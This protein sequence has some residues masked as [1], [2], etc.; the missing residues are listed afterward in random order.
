MARVKITPHNFK[1]KFLLSSNTKMKLT[2]I[3]IYQHRVNVINNDRTALFTVEMSSYYKNWITAYECYG[4]D[5]SV[6]DFIDDI[7][8]SVGIDENLLKAII[9]METRNCHSNPFHRAHPNPFPININYQLWEPIVH[10]LGYSM[11]DIKYSEM[12]RVHLAAVVLKRIALR[13][14]EPCVVRVATLYNSLNKHETSSYGHRVGEIYLD[15][16]W[17]KYRNT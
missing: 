4:F 17:E 6:L 14:N 15:K 13:L 16:I 1:E 9:Y 5:C 2:N 10:Q 12:A 7:A 8:N 3:T 11:E